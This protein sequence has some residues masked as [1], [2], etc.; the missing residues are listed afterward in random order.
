M[1]WSIGIRTWGFRRK[2]SENELMRPGVV[3]EFEHQIDKVPAGQEMAFLMYIKQK[4]ESEQPWVKVD[5]AECGSHLIVQARYVASEVQ[6]M[7]EPTTVATIVAIIQAVALIFAIAV[8]TY[9]IYMVVSALGSS[10]FGG[11]VGGLLGL[12]IVMYF[13]SFFM[14]MFRGITELI[15]KPPKKEKE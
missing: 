3:Y 11:L 2:V 6:A 4:I 5:Y 8:I 7:A 15:P 10:E 14:N 1:V 13:L 12:F 9:S